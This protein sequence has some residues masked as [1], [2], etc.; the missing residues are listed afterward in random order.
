MLISTSQA[1]RTSSVVRTQ[2]PQSTP[3]EANDPAPTTPR[4][5]VGARIGAALGKGLEAVTTGAA[6]LEAFPKFIYPSVLDATAAERAV[7]TSTLDQLPLHHVGEVSTIS[8]VPNIPSGKPGWVTFGTAKDYGLTS[9]INL[10][11]KTLTTPEAMVDTLIH[12]VG[13]TTD[14][15]QKPFRVGPYP[16]DNGPYGKGPHV[17]DYAETNHFEDYAETY[18]EYHQRPE[19]LEKVNPEKYADQVENNQPNLLE[20]LVDRKEF[21]ETGKFLG[22]L[23]GPNK[24]TRHL[25]DSAIKLSGGVHAL[26]GIEQWVA[27]GSN[28]NGL[29]HAQGILSTASGLVMLSGVAPLAGVGLQAASVALGQSVKRGELSPQEVESTIALPVRPLEM[30]LGRKPQRIGEDHRP[31]KVLAVATGG[32][33]GGTVGALAGPYLGVLGGYHLAGAVGGA[34]GLVAGGTLGFLGGTALG[35]RAGAKLAELAA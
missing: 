7:I 20:K 16:S 35:G 14:F 9:R 33:I 22:D 11:R 31:G 3:G 29:Q 4:D 12:E 32:A 24:P 15:A 8:M 30:M 2:A 5:G 18:Q 21:R 13:H 10:S 26:H 23:M 27:S 17:T 6:V 28:G 19:N 1:P 34:V 25:V